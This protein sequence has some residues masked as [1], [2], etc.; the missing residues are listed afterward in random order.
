MEYRGF[1]ISQGEGEI[2]GIKPGSVTIIRGET[3]EEVREG[4]DEYYDSLGLPE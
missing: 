3:E 2:V 4:I 1:I